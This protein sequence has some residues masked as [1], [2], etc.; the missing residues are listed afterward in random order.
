MSATT[1]ATSNFIVPDATFIV[2]LI[3]F[4]VMFGVLAKFVLPPINKAITSRREL[5]ERRAAEAAEAKE[6]MTAAEAD[7]RAALAEAR[8]GA[9]QVR[10][11]ARESG[12]QVLAESRERAH[13]EA[14]EILDDAHRTLAAERD[15]AFGSLRGRLDGIATEL[16]GKILGESV[17]DDAGRDR[18]VAGFLAELDGEPAAAGPSHAGAPTTTRGA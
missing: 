15:E 5:L 13:G 10:E 8:H 17:V 1:V 9:S 16:S 2:E 18:V 7:Y 11:Q 6:K 12:A 14:T 3:I 4:F